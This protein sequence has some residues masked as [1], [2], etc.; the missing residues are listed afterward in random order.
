MIYP[1]RESDRSSKGSPKIKIR[2]F[3]KVI[4]KNRRSYIVSVKKQLSIA[5]LFV[6]FSTNIFC[7]LFPLDGFISGL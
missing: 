3:A 2:M 5:A 6:K 1:A 7:I 4:D